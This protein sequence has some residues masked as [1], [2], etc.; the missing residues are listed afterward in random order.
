LNESLTTEEENSLLAE[1]VARDDFRDFCVVTDVNY[2]PQWFHDQIAELLQSVYERVKNGESPRIMI[3]MPPRHGKSELATKKFPAWVLGKSPEFPIIVSTYSQ[4]LSTKFGQGTRDI[5]NSSSYQNIFDTRLRQDTK[6]KA[7]WMTQKDGG[8]EAVGVG[9]AITGKGFKIGIIDDPFK[10]DEE[11]ESEVIRD[12]IWNWYSTTFYTRQEG[13][14]AII[15]INTRW[16]DADLS[17]RL[18]AQEKESQ[19]NGDTDYDKWELINFTAVAEKQEANREEGSPLWPD[20]FSLEQLNRTK[21]ALGPYKWSALYQQN[22]VDEESQEFKTAW[23]KK[24]SLEEVSKLKTR[25]FLTIDPASAMR[26]KSDN[27]GAVLNFI[28]RENKW[29]LIAWKLRLNAPDLIDFMFK[30]YQDYGFEK[31]GIEQGVYEQVIKPYLEVEMRQRNVFFTVVVLKHEQ[32]AK[33]LRIRGL[34]PYYSSGTIYHI[35][36]MCSDLEEELVRFPKGAHDDVA[37]AEAYQIQIAEE[38]TSTV[39]QQQSAPQEGYYEELGI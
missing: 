13:N 38:T 33:V 10:N 29:N 2:D 31:V 5:I 35:E 20:K 26:D 23:F 28:D 34:I 19:A 39:S 32:Q 24:R 1:R 22:P 9:G 17:G 15:L 3:T 12:N 6:A 25:K 11:A 7:S 14:A 16:H 18:L 27:I 21:K 37:D 8:Y 4:D 36:G 30:V